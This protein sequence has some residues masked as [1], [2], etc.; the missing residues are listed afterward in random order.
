MQKKGVAV[1]CRREALGEPVL[2]RGDAAA[3]V[4]SPPP[5]S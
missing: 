3:I 5:E 1:L 4:R 2:S